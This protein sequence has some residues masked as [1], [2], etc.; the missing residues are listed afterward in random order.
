MNRTRLQLSLAVAA[1]VGMAGIAPAAELLVADVSHLPPP[2][3]DLIP[4]GT[5]TNPAG[6]KLTADGTSLLLDGR[7]WLPAM[8]EFHYSR[9]PQD[10]W[11]DELLKMKAGGIDVVATY[12][13]WIHHEEVEGRWDWTGQR[14]LRRFLQLADEVG[15]R[16][17]VRV[18]PWDHGEVRQG[19]FPDW[20]IAKHLKL[21][22]NDPAYLAE[23]AK[24][25][26]QVAGQLKGELWKDGGPVI[27]IQVE[28]EYAGRADHL[29]RLKQMAVD[30]GIDVPL[31]DRTGWPRMASPVPFGH[32]LPLYGGYAEGFWDRE[33]TPMPGAYWKEFTFQPIRT[34][35][36]VAT[37]T[38]GARRAEDEANAQRYPYLTCELGGGMMTSYHR[39]ILGFPMDVLSVAMVRIGSGSNLPGYYMY[40]GGEN[41]DAKTGITL[42]ERQDTPYTNYNDLPVKTYDFQAP[43]GEFGQVR[44]HYHLLRRL[45][46]FLHDF[47]PG[48]TCMP[49]VLPTEQPKRKSDA[50]TLRWSVRS[51]GTAGFVF[52]N[53]YQRLMPMPAKPGVQWRVA[54]SG[55]ESLAVPATPITVPA[56]S[57]FVLPFNLPLGSG[58]TL[59][60]ATAQPVCTLDDGGTHYTVFAEVPGVPTEFSIRG[61]GITVESGGHVLTGDGLTT[62]R[63]V[64]PGTA[65]AVSF[66]TADGRRQRLLLLDDATSLQLYKLTVAGRPRLLL[67]RAAVLA[68]GD[69]IRL[70]AENAADLTVAVFPPPLAAGGTDDGPFRR[71]DLHVAPAASA[72][73]TVEQVKRPGPPREIPMGIAKVA[74]E[75]TDADFDAAAV[76]HV[77]L[78]DPHGKA[79]LRVRYVGD[80][81]RAYLGDKLLTDNFYNGTPFDVGLDR[82]GPDVYSKGITL[83]VLPLRKDA[84]VYLLDQSRPDFAG[85][86]SV[87]RLEGVDLVQPREAT[88]SFK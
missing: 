18:G 63:A 1:L 12:V 71:F 10:Q 60:Y 6:A 61:S 15:L 66:K 32:L 68:D 24:L 55:G 65:A 33:L 17:V 37:D 2:T 88:L 13:F 3:H 9:Y 25:Y 50:D 78:P 5:A 76:W 22:S 41:P 46:L 11:R 72:A 31:Y 77:T 58:A 62:V 82:F 87:A 84:P 45:H 42:N 30:A 81:A 21:R 29:L 86:E 38:F 75:P 19:G 74:S 49:P 28:N 80:V 47:G 53:N 40:H 36:T 14:D 4:L 23:V 73:P 7:P 20:L 8:G 26:G 43:L 35:T 59:A 27:G 34:D 57:A 79:I 67:T 85:Q 52:V 54:L 69:S 64:K 48:L 39:R 51:D 83:K 70:Q 44:P 56:D 16:A